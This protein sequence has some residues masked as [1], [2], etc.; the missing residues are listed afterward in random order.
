MLVTLTGIGLGGVDD[1]RAQRSCD[2]ADVSKTFSIECPED[3]IADS[4]DSDKDEDEDDDTEG[5]TQVGGADIE[6]KIP[7]SGI[8]L[9]FP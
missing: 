3:P 7:S 4:S 5:D 8:S 2:R 9:P 1:S 6:S